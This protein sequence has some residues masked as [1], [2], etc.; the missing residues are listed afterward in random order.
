MSNKKYKDLNWNLTQLEKYYPINTI[1]NHYFI[2]SMADGEFLKDYV[3]VYKI[4]DDNNTKDKG[5]RKI[6]AHKIQVD[7]LVL[8][9]DFNK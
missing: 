6:H 7:Y 4:I 1:V 2:G 5:T 3:V 8:K 9:V